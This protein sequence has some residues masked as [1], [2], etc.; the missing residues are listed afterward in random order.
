MEKE[1]I[2]FWALVVMTA[3]VIHLSVALYRAARRRKAIKGILD[4]INDV[5]NITHAVVAIRANKCDNDEARRFLCEVKRDFELITMPMPRLYRLMKHKLPENQLYIN[6]LY[7]V[8]EYWGESSL[9]NE[10][11]NQ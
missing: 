9:K 4:H 1:L 8:G 7:W 10:A 5:A 6:A 11:N 3:I 2:L